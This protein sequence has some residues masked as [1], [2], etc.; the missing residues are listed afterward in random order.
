VTCR[1]NLQLELGAA[2]IAAMERE[3]RPAQRFDGLLAMPGRCLFLVDRFAFAFG[4]FG[5]PP[6]A[7]RSPRPTLRV[8]RPEAVVE[9]NTIE[10]HVYVQRKAFAG[11]PTICG[12]ITP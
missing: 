6:R 10:V 1:R 7:S 5:L 2:T 3:D 8:L 12:S 11:G 4:G 9:E